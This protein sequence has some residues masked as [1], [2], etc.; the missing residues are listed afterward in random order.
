MPKKSKKAKSDAENIRVMSQAERTTLVNRIRIQMLSIETDGLTWENIESFKKLQ[1]MF[2][3]YEKFGKE[4]EVCLPLPEV[5]DRYLEVRLRNNKNK[6]SMV[7]IRHG[8]ME[9]SCDKNNL[10]EQP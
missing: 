3:L 2:D 8:S 1:I 4:F 10:P 9:Q 6:Q 7:I 5:G